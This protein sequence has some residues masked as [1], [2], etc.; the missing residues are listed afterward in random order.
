MNPRSFWE[1]G[2]M[3]VKRDWPKLIALIIFFMLL[4]GYY[5]R[6]S[7]QTRTFILPALIFVAAAFVLGKL[8]QLQYEVR[9]SRLTAYEIVTQQLSFADIDGN[10]RIAI[11]AAA[12]STIMSFYDAS[13]AELLTM[14]LKDGEPQFRMTGEKGVALLTIS[15]DGRP[16]FTIRGEGDDVIWSA[17]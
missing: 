7:V 3:I 4:G 5:D 1:E 17:P 11:S 12:D 14:E 16:S 9:T 13:H 2:Q 15:E 6:L 8:R 10:E